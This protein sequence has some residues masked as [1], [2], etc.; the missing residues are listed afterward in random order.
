MWFATYSTECTTINSSQKLPNIFCFTP[1]SINSLFCELLRKFGGV[2]LELCETISGC[3]GKVVGG[4]IE[5]NYS[6][7]IGKIIKKYIRYYKIL[8]NIP[9]SLFDE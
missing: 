4:Q 5:E 8:F 3:I 6:K 7:H 1:Y 9:N 2:F